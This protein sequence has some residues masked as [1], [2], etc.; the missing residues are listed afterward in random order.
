MCSPLLVM[1]ENAPGDICYLT[2]GGRVMYP[3]IPWCDLLVDG[4]TVQVCARL[5]GGMDGSNL[6]DPGGLNVPPAVPPQVA[7]PGRR[8]F[9]RLEC[10]GWL[11]KGKLLTPGNTVAQ[12]G[13]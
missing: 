9:T 11:K 13:F 5:P 10:Q 6:D 7:Q 3:D 1:V 4:D 2:K 8:F 12:C